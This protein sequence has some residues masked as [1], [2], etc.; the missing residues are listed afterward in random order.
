MNFDNTP[1]PLDFRGLPESDLTAYFHWFVCNQETHI[2]DLETKVNRSAGGTTW[3]ANK[4][5]GSLNQLGDWFASQVA[6]RPRTKAELSAIADAA[7]YPV[8]IPDYELCPEVFMLARDVGMYLASTLC[9]LHPRLR[10]ELPIQDK[11]FVDYG[12]PILA[13]FGSVSLNPVRI[14]ETLAYAIA[15]KKYDGR[16]LYSIAEYWDKQA[17]KGH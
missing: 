9:R 17:R 10:W 2:L 12:Q 11:K 8:S 1:L 7:P 15:S 14:V 13:G 5:L 3:S 4:S 6:T 16:R